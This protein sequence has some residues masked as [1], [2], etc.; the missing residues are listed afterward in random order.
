MGAAQAPHAIPGEAPGFR[1]GG[2]PLDRRLPSDYNFPMGG[3][4]I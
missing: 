1:L 4:G 3:M 2:S